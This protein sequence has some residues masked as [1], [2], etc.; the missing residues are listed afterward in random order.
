ME[1]DEGDAFSSEYGL[2][3]ERIRRVTGSQTSSAERFAME[4][5]STLRNVTLTSGWPSTG[6]IVVGVGTR[7]RL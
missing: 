3:T 5:T 4:A 1:T 2:V 7:T 6:A